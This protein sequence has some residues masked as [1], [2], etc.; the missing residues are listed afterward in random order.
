MREVNFLQTEIS[1]KYKSFFYG[2]RTNFC[3][4][5]WQEEQRLF[6]DSKLFAHCY[7]R[8]N[9]DYC[10]FC[11]NFRTQLMA[12]RTTIICGFQT[13][14]RT[15]FMAG[16]TVIISGFQTF[17][18]TLFMAGGTTNICGFKTIFRLC[19]WREEQRLF[20]KSFSASVYG[21]KNN[22]YL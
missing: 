18:C 5:F 2:F 3:T 20:S 19:L 14:F 11:I 12:G 17:S 21:G 13:K 16:R 10:G 8:K 22:D 4:L 1:G 15:Q 7:G 6:A 9:N